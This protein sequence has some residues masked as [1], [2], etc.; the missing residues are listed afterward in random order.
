M[1]SFVY[2]LNDGIYG[3]LLDAV[4]DEKTGELAC[5]PCI[6]AHASET[7]RVTDLNNKITG[8]EDLDFEG[9]VE[10]EEANLSVELNFVRP[11]LEFAGMELAQFKTC[12]DEDLMKA[13][14]L[15]HSLLKLAS[16]LDSRLDPQDR[17]SDQRPMRA[18][19]IDRSAI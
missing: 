13:A 6:P 19:S 9:G 14:C 7:P 11:Y 18:H 1:K 3:D 10:R 2:M 12:M 16:L 5:V 17:G 8:V 15:A 4:A